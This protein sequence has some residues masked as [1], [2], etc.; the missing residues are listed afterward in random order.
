MFKE[1]VSVKCFLILAYSSIC[2]KDGRSVIF[3]NMSLPKLP[4]RV[5]HDHLHCEKW[6]I[7]HFGWKKSPNVS[8]PTKSEKT[9]CTDARFQAHLL[10]LIMKRDSFK[11]CSWTKY[12]LL[13]HKFLVMMQGIGISRWV[14]TTHTGYSF[15]K[16]HR[17]A[18]AHSH[19]HV[20]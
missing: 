19:I 16:W 1:T 14:K 7:D 8:G 20:P 17:S 11:I 9:Y 12:E 10:R 4:Y 18:K 5:Y 2:V 15:S 3:W 13:R 6:G